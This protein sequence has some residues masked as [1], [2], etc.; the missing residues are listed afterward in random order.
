[1]IKA[2]EINLFE[3]RRELHRQEK[4]FGVSDMSVPEKSI[5]A[6]IAERDSTIARIQKHDYFKDYSLSTIKRA[7]GSLL[8]GGEITVRISEHDKRERILSL[9]LYKHGNTKAKKLKKL[10]V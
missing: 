3:L 7:I 8:S 9:D 6:F 2:V 5:F 10:T 4:M 1:M